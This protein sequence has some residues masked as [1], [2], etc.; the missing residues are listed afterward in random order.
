MTRNP[1]AGRH[2]G[3]EP[4]RRSVAGPRPALRGAFTA[5]VT[6]FAADGAHRRGRLSRARR[7]AGPGRDRRPRPG[8]H[9][10]R[11]AHAVAGRARPAHRD[12]RRGRGGQPCA[13]AAARRRG[14][15]HQRHPRLDRGHAPGRR[16]GRGRGAG[17][18]ALLQPA[19]PADARGPLPGHRGRGRPADRRLQRALADGDQRRGRHVP[20]AGRASARDRGQ[21]GERQHRAAR[22]DL[23][24]P[25]ARRGRA[26]GRRRGHARGAGD[27]R[28]R[29]G[30]GGRQPGPGRDGGAVR[31]GARRRLGRGAAPPRPMAAPVPRQLPGR[32]QPGAGQGRAPRDGPD[33]A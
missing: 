31:R 1:V 17:R 25:A 20:A 16:P 32:A 19:G 9:D 23:P 2:P 18:R 11:G 28:R 6:P 33:R 26:R 24:G 15:R 30:L 5:L 13:K 3:T 21:G 4:D 7:V 8:R 27:G 22:G 10:R 14:H 12:R 29:R